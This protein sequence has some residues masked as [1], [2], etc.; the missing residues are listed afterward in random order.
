M[1]YPHAYQSNPPL[2]KA[3]LLSTDFKNS[4]SENL[5][6][7]SVSPRKASPLLLGA[8][9]ISGHIGY[10]GHTDSTHHPYFP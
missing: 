6:K 4:K 7:S 2:S 5:R 3:S 1:R 9:L 8:Y 10:R